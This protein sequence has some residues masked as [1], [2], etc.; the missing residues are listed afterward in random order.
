VLKLI[1]IRRYNKYSPYGAGA[2]DLVQMGANVATV[3]CPQGPRVRTFVGRRDNPAEPPTGL[4]P[5]PNHEPEVLLRLFA[6]KTIKPNGLIALLGAH[7]TSQQR[8]FKPE[9]SYDPQD[10]TPGVWDVNVYFETLGG[11]K[12]PRVFSF[13]SDTKFSKHPL[14]RDLWKIFSQPGPGQSRWNDDYAKEY[15]RMS[16]LGVQNI[17]YLVEC[18]SELPF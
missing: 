12:P 6:D 10:T 16:M 17:N 15:V 9:R 8:F 2:A 1:Q 11:N 4:L 13:P 14:T 18:T 3:V 5:D 7:S